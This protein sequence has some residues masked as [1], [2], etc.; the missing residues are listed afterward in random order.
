MHLKLEAPNVH[1]SPAQAT[2]SRNLVERAYNLCTS[3]SC[4]VQSGVLV[5]MCLWAF[6][7]EDEVYKSMTVQEKVALWEGGLCPGKEV[8]NHCL[9]LPAIILLAACA[10]LFGLLTLAASS[11]P[12]HLHICFM[13][14]CYM[15]PSCVCGMKDNKMTILIGVLC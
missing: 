11:P 3:N 6:L 10:L 15:H 5:C 14:R 13:V 2:S 1:G 9:M 7:Q 8:S 4:Q 12:L